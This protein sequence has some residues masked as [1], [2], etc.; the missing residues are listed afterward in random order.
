MHAQSIMPLI[1]LVKSLRR[2]L[3]VSPEGAQALHAAL[4]PL[5]LSV[6]AA[7]EKYRQELPLILQD[8]GG[9]GEIEE[10]MM[11]YSWSREKYQPHGNGDGNEESR[12]VDE[13]VWKKAWMEKLERRELVPI[14][15]FL[16]FLLN[17]TYRVLIQILLYFYVLS[18]PLS[19]PSPTQSTTVASPSRKRRRETHDPAFPIVNSTGSPSKKRRRETLKPPSPTHGTIVTPSKKRRKQTHDLPTPPKQVF[20]PTISIEATMSST[21]ASV[22]KSSAVDIDENLGLEDRLE[23]F[24]DK[25]CLWQLLGSITPSESS[26]VASHSAAKDQRDWM[27]V[28]CEDVIE[29]LCVPSE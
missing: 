8:G 7:G 12:K 29:P 27:Q 26:H 2:R 24:M 9:A 4:K 13:E 17:M 3:V 11:W 21:P 19:V 28:F 6:R 22:S 15:K 16:M 23:F 1:F 20:P 5:L 18:V 14:Y 25:L 10:S